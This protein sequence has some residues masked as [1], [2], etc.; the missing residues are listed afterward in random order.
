[1]AAAFGCCVAL[2]FAAANTLDVRRL[3]RAC[4]IAW[5]L[6]GWVALCLVVSFK[7]RYPSLETAPRP[8]QWQLGATVAACALMLRVSLLRVAELEAA[9]TGA[10]P[11][12]VARLA[13]NVRLQLVAAAM[14]VGAGAVM[15]WA[16]L[17]AYDL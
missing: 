8:A 12:A 16:G 7:T 2:A 5:V 14:L 3:G 13:R 17:A 11:A 15:E 1:M 9:S 4:A 6:F 10:E